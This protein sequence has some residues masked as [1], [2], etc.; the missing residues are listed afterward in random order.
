MPTLASRI[1]TIS[2]GSLRSLFSLGRP[3]P[4]NYRN[5]MFY[6]GKLPPG[7]A[8]FMF[9]DTFCGPVSWPQGDL[10]RQVTDM[11]FLRKEIATWLRVHNVLQ[12]F[13]RAR[14]LAARGPDPPSYRNVV[15]YQ[16]E[17]PPGSADLM[18][19]DTLCGPTSWPQEPVVQTA[20]SLSLD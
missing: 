20:R 1:L 3:D 17:L 18:F 7:S 13:L 6:K 5:V 9:Y 14:Q 16:R 11:S 2:L 10:T 12:H 15:F 19:Y 8:D 4:L